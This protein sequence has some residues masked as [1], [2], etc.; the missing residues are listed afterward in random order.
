MLQVGA[1][2]MNERPFMP[3]TPLLFYSSPSH[4]FLILCCFRLSVAVEFNIAFDKIPSGNRRICPIIKLFVYN[5]IID[6]N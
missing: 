2:G 4:G 5:L 6:R 3:P 1:K